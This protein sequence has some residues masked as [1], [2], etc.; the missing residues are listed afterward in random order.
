MPWVVMV[1]QLPTLQILTVWLNPGCFSKRHIAREH[2]VPH[3]ELVLCVGAMWVKM[4]LPGESIF[5]IMDIPARG[6][7]KF[8]TC[9]YQAILLPVRMGR[10]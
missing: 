6:L 2:G 8:F 3:P 4:K 5:K 7:E 9:V 10:M 1:T